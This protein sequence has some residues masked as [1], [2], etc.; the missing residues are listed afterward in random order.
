MSVRTRLLLLCLGIILPGAIGAIWGLNALHEQQRVTA[1]VNL[2]EITRA[3]AAVVDR[4]LYRRESTLRTL[5]L[6][7]SLR[8]G[9]IASFYTYA[10]AVAAS[11][12][13]SI[14]LVGLDGVQLMNTRAPFGA[15]LPKAAAFAGWTGTPKSDAGTTRSVATTSYPC[16]TR[17]R[18]VARP[19]LPLAPVTQTRM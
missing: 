11:P 9:D 16:S 19:S 15:E 18:V 17:S 3:M 12:E 13:T 6:A 8:E 4:E 7:P 10:K 2:T 5:A 14:V 1:S